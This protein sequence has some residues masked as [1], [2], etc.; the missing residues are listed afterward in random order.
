MISYFMTLTLLR[1][2]FSNQEFQKFI[3]YYLTNGDR[4]GK[5][6]V[7]IKYEVIYGLL[8]GVFS[9]DLSPF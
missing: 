1:V 3:H 8:I 9:F 6:T 5:V 7:V 4:F 2:N